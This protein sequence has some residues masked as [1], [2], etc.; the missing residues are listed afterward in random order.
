[1]RLTI[2]KLRT[3]VL[4]AGVLLLVSLGLFL[5]VGKIKNPFNRRDLPQRLGI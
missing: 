5:T 3:L 1:V 2:E 4:G